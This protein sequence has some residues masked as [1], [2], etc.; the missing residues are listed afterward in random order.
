MTQIFRRAT[1]E[2]ELADPECPVER[3]WNLA[4]LYPAE[5]LESPLYPLLTL[6]APERWLAMEAGCRDRWIRIEFSH[7]SPNDQHLFIADCAEHVSLHVLGPTHAFFRRVRQAIETRRLLAREEVSRGHWEAVQ[8]SLGATQHSIVI[9]VEY[10]AIN[11][12]KLDDLGAVWS[13][14]YAVATCLCPRCRPERH[15]TVDVLAVTEACKDSDDELDK[16]R[17]WQWLRL[18]TYVRTASRNG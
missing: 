5:A 16:E 6:E 9:P 2:L 11:A 12:I 13:A 15:A 18:L 8:A 3:W 10:E 1:F 17:R 14:G 4:E 7:L